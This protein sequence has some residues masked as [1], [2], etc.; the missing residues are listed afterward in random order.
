MCSQCAQSP[1][2][3]SRQKTETMKEEGVWRDD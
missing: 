2:L 3:M 1:G